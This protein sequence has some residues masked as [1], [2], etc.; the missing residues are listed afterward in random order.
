MFDEGR[1]LRYQEESIVYRQGDKQVTQYQNGQ[2][3]YHQHSP[4]FLG[5][6]ATR[7]SCQYRF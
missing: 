1:H 3:T 5:I 7:S 4:D 6:S 2:S